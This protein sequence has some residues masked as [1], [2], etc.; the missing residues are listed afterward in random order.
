MIVYSGVWYSVVLYSA[1]WYIVVLY[2][3]QCIVFYCIVPHGSQTDIKRSGNTADLPM[4]MQYS[5]L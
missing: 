1:V 5:P 2:N 4:P 3:V